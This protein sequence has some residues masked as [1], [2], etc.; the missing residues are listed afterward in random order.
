M[1]QEQH[2]QIKTNIIMDIE[3]A[4]EEIIQ[5]EEKTKPIAPDCSLGRLTRLEA[6]GEQQVYE[7]ALQETRIR[8]N[9]LEYALRKVDTPD[10]GVCEE[11]E[12]DIA[13]G[14]L[15]IMPESTR[16]IQCAD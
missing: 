11:C 1:T 10:Y 2:A 14:R 5:L 8:L 3:K 4:K 16:C 15:M 6:M 7:H 9:R 13:I 12:D